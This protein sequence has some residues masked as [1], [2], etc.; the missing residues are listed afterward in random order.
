M[1]G[2]RTQG[3]RAQ[4]Q[5]KRKR[6]SEGVD[7]SRNEPIT[8]KGPPFSTPHNVSGD[9]RGAFVMTG[10]PSHE[11]LHTRLLVESATPRRDQDNYRTGW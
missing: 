4:S 7:A 1:K 9:L 8:R 3:L 6:D 5:V 2:N 10:D 11:D